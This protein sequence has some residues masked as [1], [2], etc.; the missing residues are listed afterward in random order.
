QIY[1]KKKSFRNVPTIFWVN[2]SDWFIESIAW[3]GAAVSALGMLGIYPAILLALLWA[4]YFSFY[5]IGSPFLNYQWDV[6]LLEVGILGVLYAIQSPPP[7]LA[8]YLL[9]FFLF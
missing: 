7:L 1:Y 9:W 8:T 5:N 4:M 3:A 6:L 2:S